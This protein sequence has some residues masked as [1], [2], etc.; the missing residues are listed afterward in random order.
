MRIRLFFASLLSLALALSFIACEGDQGPIGPSGP[1]GPA[2]PTGPEGQNGAENCLDCHGNSQ[3]ITSKVFQWENSVH[4]L[5][6]HYDRNDASCAVC[7]TSQG[8]LEVVGTGATAAAAAIEDPLPPNCYSCH[9]IHQTYTEADWALTSTEPFTFWVGGETADIGA[10]NLCLNCHLA[11]IPSPALPVPG[12][13]DDE[14]VN[15][16]NKRYGP[17]HGSQGVLFT[18]NAA[19]EVDGPA[20]YGNS[21]HTTLAANSC[22]TCHMAKVEGGRALGGHTFRVA[23]DDGSG[24]LTINY[25]GCSACHDDE[26]ELYTLVEDTQMEID[27]LILELGTRLNQLGLID[28]DLEYAV[29]PQDFSNL[30]LGILWN[31]QYIRED[32]SFG[33]H[34]YKYAKALLENSIA[35]LD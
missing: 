4:L 13:A 19:Y 23:E 3:L 16:T 30:Q 14:L 18:G 2:G 26:D 9:Q 22:A 20:E 17:H 27:A 7:H 29:V 5:G 6:G 21:L 8:F 25:N 32:K 1:I 11:R 35:A 28:A 12:V 24:N 34:N 31:Y 33:V 10:G 15:I